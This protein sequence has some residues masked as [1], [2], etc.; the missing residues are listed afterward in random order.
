M[1][2]LEP[3]EKTKKRNKKLF[4]DD[5]F[6]VIKKKKSKSSA[7]EVKAEI[8]SNSV[9]EPKAEE[10]QD[11]KA[12]TEPNHLPSPPKTS[13]VDTQPESLSSEDLVESF[14]TAHT[15]SEADEIFEIRHTNTES[16]PVEVISDESDGEFD[17]L[18]KA[19]TS[20]KQ[21]DHESD[22]CYDISI[23]SKLGPEEKH[24]ITSKGNKT[25][26][27]ILDDI[28]IQATHNFV[29]FR[30]KGGC[31]IWIK[32][33]SELKPFFR[34]STLRI[35]PSTDPTANT[36]ID[37]LYIPE[38][39]RQNFEEIYPEFNEFTNVNDPEEDLAIVDVKDEKAEEEKVEKKDEYFIIG[40][41]GKDN[42]RIEAEVGP[43][44][45][46]KALLEHYLKSKE[47]DA[48]SVSKA[49]LVFD[50][51]DLDLEGVVG[52]TELEEDFEVQVY[53]N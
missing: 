17:E 23:T 46:I 4:D 14:H 53:I 36:P 19:H 26:M 6:F 20:Q 2:K 12:K 44:T 48:S 25:F 28:R 21:S 31:L 5:D 10:T 29:P 8:K 22:R 45:K 40:L 27:E 39:C 13:T 18:I 35:P 41:K 32:G 11:N 15:T 47:I 37:C 7:P 52:D 50:D 38:V 9:I 34:P 3:S 49:R 24:M 43:Q 30:L 1:V 51:E 33:K 16:E 42:K